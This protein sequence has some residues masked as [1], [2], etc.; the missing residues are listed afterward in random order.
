MTILNSQNIFQSI[1]C[2]PR[3]ILTGEAISQYALRIVDQQKNAEVGVE[4]TSR[5]ITNKKLVIE[6]SLTTIDERF[7]TIEVYNRS[8]NKILFRGVAFACDTTQ[9]LDKYTM[10]FGDNT[11]PS[12]NDQTYIT[13]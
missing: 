13:L 5:T 3:D 2:F 9:S 8:T 1:T 12:A 11:L 10:Y 4:I 6:F 7:Y